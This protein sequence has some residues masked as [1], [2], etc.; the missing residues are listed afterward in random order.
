MTYP[1]AGDLQQV[2]APLSGPEP[3]PSTFTDTDKT[4]Q[5]SDSEVGAQVGSLV[6]LEALR[7]VW[8]AHSLR[9]VWFRRCIPLP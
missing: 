6:L 1:F 4:S 9:A 7:M 2:T 3:S 8:L 5:D